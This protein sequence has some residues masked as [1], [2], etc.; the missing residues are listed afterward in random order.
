[1]Q[2]FI[3]RGIIHHS[4]KDDTFSLFRV[5]YSNLS[6]KEYINHFEEL[7]A[8]YIGKDF[9]TAFPLAR[10]AIYYA[11]KERSF[12]PGTEIIM[13]PISIKGILDVYSFILSL[14]GRWLPTIIVVSTETLVP[15]LFFLNELCIVA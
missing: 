14:L 11:L 5:F 3:P 4:L 6:E 8:K 9:C 2:L 7:F 15:Q 13:P 1:M 12:S 10:T